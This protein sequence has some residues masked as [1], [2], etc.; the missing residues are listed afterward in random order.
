[1]RWQ[2]INQGHPTRRIPVAPIFDHD[3]IGHLRA[4]FYMILVRVRQQL[5]HDEFNHSRLVDR[6]LL[7][8]LNW[9]RQ[10]R[11]RERRNVHRLTGLGIRVHRDRI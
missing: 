3:L 9:R 7:A 4:I 5:T 11:S 6:C 8:P 10:V 1:M 2:R